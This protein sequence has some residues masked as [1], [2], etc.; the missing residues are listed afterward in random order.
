MSGRRAATR[1][2]GVYLLV[3][4]VSMVVSLTGVTALYLVRLR[5]AVSMMGE[6]A[7]QAR[8]DAASMIEVLAHR[9]NDTADWRST[10]AHDAWSDWTDMD[11][12][13]WRWKVIDEV[14]GS[15]ANNA[16]H[17]VRLTVHVE[18]GLAQRVLS[19]QMSP[20]RE[21]EN[22]LSN[23]SF[24]LGTTGWSSAGSNIVSTGAD[25]AHGARS[26]EVTLR[27]HSGGIVQRDVTSIVQSGVD[28]A[29]EARI[30]PSSGDEFRFVIIH[31]LLLVT[32]TTSGPWQ[33]APAGEWTR[34]SAQLSPS[35]TGTLLGS[36]F[37]I[38]SRYNRSDLLL[39]LVVLR[40]A[41]AVDVVL[42]PDP[43][44]WRYEAAP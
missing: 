31:R 19:V 20:R 22:L 3:L 36:D 25:A 32:I 18:R 10:T 39:D 24:E 35:F 37:H 41:G 17:P 6:Q 30:K 4:S 40:R 16:D 42:R 21:N 14:D 27:S 5:S 7:A 13:R 8:L 43:G 28:Y 29:V 15:L 38:Q 12:W 26:L 9:L 1:R 23:P 34:L 33:A 44:T 2:G 11:R